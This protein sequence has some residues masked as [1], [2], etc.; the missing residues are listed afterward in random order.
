MGFLR[1]NVCN[2]SE[3]RPPPPEVTALLALGAGSHG[4]AE[5][6]QQG[7]PLTQQPAEV[8]PQKSCSGYLSLSTPQ[9]SDTIPRLEG[10][11][12]AGGT[13]KGRWADSPGST[14]RGWGTDIGPPKTNG[15]QNSYFLCSDEETQVI[16]K[17]PS[18]SCP[19]SFRGLA[20]ERELR[21]HIG[22]HLT[23]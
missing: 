7:P 18:P 14:L 12:G 9:E 5:E 23:K 17:L 22:W 2:C 10:G 1:H 15:P 6:G 20:Q 8:T 11:W 13:T 4:Q 19:T 16:W 21:Q 3:G